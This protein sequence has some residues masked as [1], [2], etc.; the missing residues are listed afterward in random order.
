MAVVGDPN[1]VL[2]ELIDRLKGA[3][4]HRP[5]RA[6]E[7]SKLK[8]QV[9]DALRSRSPLAVRLNDEI[10][11]ALPRDGILAGDV[12]ITAY[13][14]W[15]LFDVYNPRTYLYPWAFATLGFG[16][17]AAIGAKV[18][19]PQKPVLAVC[20]D[21]GFLYTANELATAVQFGINVVALVV[22]DERYGILEPQQMAQFG[23]TMMTDLRNPDFAALAR[24]FDCHG[25]TIDRVEEVGP[26]LRAAFAADKPAVVELKTKLP[27]PYDW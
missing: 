9:R 4:N 27:D 8:S 3:A 13:W 11:A 6:D 19:R 18:A 17:P 7:V 12:T 24:S 21:G 10:R 1:T 15:P 20:G 14:G 16:L 23:R 22:N 2:K 26:A 25:V 5:A